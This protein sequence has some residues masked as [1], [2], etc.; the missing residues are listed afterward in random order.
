M[1]RVSS[2]NNSIDCKIRIAFYWRPSK[3]STQTVRFQTRL[4]FVETDQAWLE[5]EN[6]VRWIEPKNRSFGSAN[7]T[8]E[9]RESSGTGFWQID[10]PY[11]G[12]FDLIQVESIDAEGGWL[13]YTASP[14]NPTQQYLYRV[15]LKGGEAS[16]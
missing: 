8:V 5:N 12:S 14:E 10:L 4:V 3:A 1:D 7:A 15:A 11:A 6:P 9:A 16:D 13:Y 2:C